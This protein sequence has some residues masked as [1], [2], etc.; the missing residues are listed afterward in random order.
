MKF[1]LL[2]SVSFWVVISPLSY[3]QNTL[4][5]KISGKDLKQP[6]YAFG[7][8]HVNDEK[9]FNFGDAVFDA[10]EACEVA[11]FEIDMS[12]SNSNELKAQ[13]EKDTMFTNLMD[14]IK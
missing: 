14:H 5:F 6:S 9:A 11:A 12:K 10:I 8:M 7:T 13:I 4:L 2:I 3:S 1:R